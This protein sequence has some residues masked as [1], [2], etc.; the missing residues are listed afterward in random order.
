M[1]NGIL[2]SEFLEELEKVQREA[3]ET[4]KKRKKTSEE[5]LKTLNWL[6]LANCRPRTDLITFLENRMVYLEEDAGWLFSISTEMK[7]RQNWIRVQQESSLQPKAKLSCKG[8]RTLS[9]PSQ[10]SFGN[11]FNDH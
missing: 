4:S 1:L 8:D 6:C 9:R 11:M 3:T 5:R 10:E 7:S 2:V